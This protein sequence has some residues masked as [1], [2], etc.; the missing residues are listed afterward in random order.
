M[1]G[2]RE[3]SRW[4]LAAIHIGASMFVVALVASAFFDHS[5]WVLYAFQALI[6]VAVM[7]LAQRRSP[8]GFSCTSCYRNVE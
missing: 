5:I 8:F 7:L 6:Y 1:A 2:I 4:P 3:N